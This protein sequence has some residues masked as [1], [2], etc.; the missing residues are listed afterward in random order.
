VA[1]AA[2]NLRF[3][4]LHAESFRNLLAVCVVHG[5][6]ADGHG[7]SGILDQPGSRAHPV[8]DPS[9][10][11]KRCYLARGRMSLKRRWRRGTVPRS[12]G[13][14]ELGSAWLYKQL[15]G[16]LFVFDLL[17][18][19][20]HHKLKHTPI[21]GLEI[22][23]FI[24][25]QINSRGLVAVLYVRFISFSFLRNSCCEQCRTAYSKHEPNVHFPGTRLPQRVFFGFFLKK[26]RNKSG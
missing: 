25:H 17:C 4:W 8:R 3:Q 1:T 19:Y 12:D 20:V 14:E 22:I 18:L 6:G 24:I 16:D 9:V 5:A 11:R 7:N 21:P 15:V 26:L 23:F 2:R 10:Q 13:E